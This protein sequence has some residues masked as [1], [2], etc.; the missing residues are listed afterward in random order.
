MPYALIRGA[1]EFEKNRFTNMRD[2][3]IRLSEGQKPHI[4]FIT[5]ADS[6]IDPSLI[7]GSN[8]RRYVCYSQCRKYLSAY[9]SA[10]SE[11][12]ALEYALEVLN[13]DEIIICGHT[14]CGAMKG[15]LAS[16]TTEQLP[17][18]ELG[19]I[20]PIRCDAP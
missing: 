16:N 18:V 9:P 4:F 12:A 10:C 14:H 3:F 7:T 15:L 5:C 20:M 2:L 8:P 1:L 13:V 11:A 19:L 17:T 6:R